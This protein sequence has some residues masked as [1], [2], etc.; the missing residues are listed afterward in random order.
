[1]SYPQ[2]FFYWNSY[3]P[4]ELSYG[5]E[6]M[7]VGCKDCGKSTK[8]YHAKLCEQTVYCRECE[9]KNYIKSQIYWDKYWKNDPNL[10]T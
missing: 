7:I 3:P 9:E 1:M 6:E 2:Y 8:I 10:K 4:Y 5:I